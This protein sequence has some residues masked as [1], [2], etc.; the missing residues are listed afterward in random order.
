MKTKF[1]FAF[2]CLFPF[3]FPL[4]AQ[5]LMFEAGYVP[6]PYLVHPQAEWK[7]ERQTV[8]DTAF[9]RL[10]YKMSFW[11]GAKD[12]IYHDNRVVLVGRNGYKRD[13]S[14]LLE[15]MDWKDTKTPYSDTLQ[16]YTYNMPAYPATCFMVPDGKSWTLFRTLFTGPILRYEEKPPR[17]NWQLLPETDSVA[18]FACQKASTDYKGRH[19]VAWYSPDVAVQAG[20]YKF[21]GLPGLIVRVED[22]T[23]D[24]RWELNGIRPVNVPL[25]EKQFVTQK[26]TRQQ[27]RRLIET[28]FAQPYVFLSQTLGFRIKILDDYGN[29]RLAGEKEFS[30]QLYH[31][32]IELE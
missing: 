13:A 18:G 12:E 5:M 3:L 27:A 24:Y 21:G 4:H 7:W 19:Y 1:G 31:S 8:Y 32:P 10:R 25:G 17:F 30:L 15:V 9:V 2:L 6:D 22:T 26:A 14:E 29:S 23:G 16:R 28:M 20:P 11:N